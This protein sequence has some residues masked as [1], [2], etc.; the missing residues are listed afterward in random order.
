[1]MRFDVEFWVGAT[2]GFCVGLSLALIM[3]VGL[4]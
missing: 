3:L 4:G 2:L 1:M